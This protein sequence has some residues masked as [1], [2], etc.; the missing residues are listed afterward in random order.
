VNYPD[1]VASVFGA[2]M[3]LAAL[4]YQRRTGRGTYVDISQRELVTTMLGEHVLE[5][6]VDGRLPGLRGNEHPG[7]APND[8]YRCAGDNEWIAISVADNGEWRSLCV[9]IGR[10]ELATDERFETHLGRRANTDALR[11]ELER[12]TSGRSKQAAM[13]TLQQAGVSAGAVLTGPEMLTDPHLNARGY[14]QPIEHPRAGRQTL[15]IAPYQLSETPPGVDRPAPV[16]GADTDYVLRTI[17]Q[18]SD[19]E[20]A[21]LEAEQVTASDPQARRARR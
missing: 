7:Y 19:A 10:P 9:A 5:Y 12:W 8:C 17:L 1:Q 14:Y 15:R 16:L 20:I 2:G 18:L 13:E 6:T 4:R 21:H 11:V 3:L